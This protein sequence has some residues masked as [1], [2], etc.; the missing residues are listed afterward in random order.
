MIYY[1]VRL[2]CG[3]CVPRRTAHRYLV[4][5]VGWRYGRGFSSAEDISFR[6]RGGP[7]RPWGK[8]RASCPRCMGRQNHRSPVGL[9]P[10]FHPEI[11]K[12]R[13]AFH[14]RNPPDPR[15]LSPARQG[16]GLR[17]GVRGLAWVGIGIRGP[18]RIL[19]RRPRMQIVGPTEREPG[20]AHAPKSGGDEIPPFRE[21]S[22]G[23]K[24]SDA[25]LRVCPKEA[26][27]LFLCPGR[28]SRRWP[29]RWPR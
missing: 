20:R 29:C 2:R 18:V 23:D 19:S 14:S 12:Q 25:R 22:M 1:F 6:M 16:A 15:R 7:N 26:Y 27:K 3:R 24:L 8:R 17:T 9:A 4:R 21:T 28:I 11:R 13:N 5:S 10:I